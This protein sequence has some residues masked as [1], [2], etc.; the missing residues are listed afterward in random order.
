MVREYM[1]SSRLL[2]PRRNRYDNSDQNDDDNHRDD[3]HTHLHILPPHGLADTVGASAEAL[4]RALQV[5][6]L[7]LKGVETLAALG[8]LGDVVAHDTDGGVDFR[9]QSR[10]P[11]VS[12][13]SSSSRSTSAIAAGWNVRI[14]RLVVGC[15]FDFD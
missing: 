10:G 15:H 11:A 7:V 2:V 8:N 4:S 5:I 14:V 12:S 6:G 9:L 3:D 13:S 1:K